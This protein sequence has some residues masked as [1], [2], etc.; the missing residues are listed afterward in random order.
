[1][2]VASL[3]AA[4]VPFALAADWGRYIC[5][6]SVQAF[7]LAVIYSDPTVHSTETAK[8]ASFA[9][10]AMALQLALLVLYGLTWRLN[11]F[12]PNHFSALVP[13]LLFK[14]LGN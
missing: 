12:V 14:Y 4:L 3:A 10:S 2:Y 11:H 1:L 9:G 13:G 6:L 8:S 7:V 5:L